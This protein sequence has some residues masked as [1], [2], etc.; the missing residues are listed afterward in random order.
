MVKA[1]FR[2]IFFSSMKMV[3]MR[4]VFM[5]APQK[6]F[7]NFL[8]KEHWSLESHL[9]SNNIFKNSWSCSDIETRVALGSL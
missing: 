7:I 2:D 9:E 8:I 3:F 6:Y 5:N 1:F 4:K